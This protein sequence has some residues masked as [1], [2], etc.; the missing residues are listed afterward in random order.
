M[1]VFHRVIL[2]FIFIAA[3]MLPAHSEYK[4]GFYKGTVLVE[5]LGKKQPVSSGMT[6]PGNAVVSAGEDS[7]A[8]VYSSETDR[9]FSIASG[10]K[11]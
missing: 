2:S 9:V 3:A 10:T 1:R 6:L 5:I 8:Y 4:L 7:A 11:A